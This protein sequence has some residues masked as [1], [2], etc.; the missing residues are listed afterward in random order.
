MFVKPLT[1]PEERARVRARLEE[2]RRQL[3]AFDREVDNLLMYCS[4]KMDL[5]STRERKLLLDCQALRATRRPLSNYQEIEVR[6]IVKQLKLR[7][8]H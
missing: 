6:K 5:L 4:G 2:A 1:D 8:T 7:V 3:Q